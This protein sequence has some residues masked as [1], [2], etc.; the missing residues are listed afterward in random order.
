ML[1]HMDAGFWNARW[2]E[3]RIGFHEGRPNSF[4]AKYISRFGEGRTILVPLCGKTED[5]LY[6]RSHGHRVVG[7]EL[8]ELAARAFFAEHS[9]TPRE[10]RLGDFLALESD[11]L[12]IWVG[13]FFSIT[14][15]HVGD[16]D[17]FYDRA[18]LV[19]LPPEL[20]S[21][22][23]EHLQNLL[24]SRL[25]GLLVTYEYDQ[26]AMAGP[27]FSVLKTEV[28]ESWKDVALTE[29]DVESADA[30]RLREEGVKAVERCYWFGH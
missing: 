21:R 4:L 2:R 9:L 14:R 11:G 18:A 30:P 15:E 6:L 20:R 5:L 24:K 12:T 13:D 25:S 7:I 28:I 16:V 27:P 1:S 22:Y 23:R 3:G 10:T 29:L 19:A 8:S 17:A 26:N